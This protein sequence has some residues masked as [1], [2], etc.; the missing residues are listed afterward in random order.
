MHRL[1]GVERRREGVLEHG[2]VLIRDDARVHR[3]LA[4]AGGKDELST[5]SASFPFAWRLSSSGHI[6]TGQMGIIH[7]LHSLCEYGAYFGEF[8]AAVRSSEDLSRGP[9][10]G[11]V[12]SSEELSTEELSRGMVFMNI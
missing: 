12:R 11:A 7:Q 5:Q 1:L 4:G 6:L 9:V 8:S 3:R 10:Q 2:I